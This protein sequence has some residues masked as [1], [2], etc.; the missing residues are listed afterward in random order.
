MKTAAQQAIDEQTLQPLFKCGDCD[1][2]I[3]VFNG[4]F[5]RTCEHTNAVIIATSEAAKAVTS[6]NN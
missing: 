4:R 2:I 1:E 3:I 6:G 5:F